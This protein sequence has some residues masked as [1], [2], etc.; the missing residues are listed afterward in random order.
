MRIWLISAAT[1]LTSCQRHEEALPPVPAAPAAPVV[2]ADGVTLVSPGRDP[3]RPIRYH[4]AKGTTSPIALSIDVNMQE[5]AAAALAGGGALPTLVLTGSLVVD[6][7]LPNGDM[8]VHVRIE[9]ASAK[10]RGGGQATADAFAAQAKRYEG[11]SEAAVLSATGRLSQ[12]HVDLDGGS[13]D[14]KAQLQT[15]SNQFEQI[16]I[17]LPAAPIGAGASW[18]TE[19]PMTTNGVTMTVKTTTELTAIDGDKITYQSSV[20]VSGAGQHAQI[21][22]L[23]VELHHVSGSGGG[24]GSIELGSLAVHG[25]F[26]TAVHLDVAV[27]GETAQLG[28][29]MSVE[30]N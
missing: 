22:G 18:T 27:G 4:L 23:D 7:V 13:A 9:H 3:K 30:I 26:A 21:A 16:A 25:A 2:S 10:P 12:T 19:K 11:F 17:P 14:A 28:M 15:M 1:V 6:D 29:T 5:G 8:A 24:S 20:E